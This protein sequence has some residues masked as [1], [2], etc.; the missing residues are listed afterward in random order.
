LAHF[1]IYQLWYDV[2][3]ES[4]NLLEFSISIHTYTYTYTYWK[5]VV[6]FI[7]TVTKTKQNPS[8]K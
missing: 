2:D 7:T 8:N 3:N 4:Q 1:S 5:K 6:N